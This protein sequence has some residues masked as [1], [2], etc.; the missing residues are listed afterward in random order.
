MEDIHSQT[1]AQVFGEPVTPAARRLAK[2]LNFVKHYGGSAETL[3]E[4]AG[5]L[6]HQIKLLEEV[7][8]RAW[9]HVPGSMLPFQRF[10]NQLGKAPP[11]MILDEACVMDEVCLTR[12]AV[13][14][15]K[16]AEHLSRGFSLQGVTSGRSKSC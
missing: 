4:K 11:G 6:P 9:S 3:A 14:E 7:Y 8:R 5:L 10:S 15:I 1:A 12:C 13:L 2:D 16:I